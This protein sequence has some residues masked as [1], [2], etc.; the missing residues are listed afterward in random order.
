MSKIG[1]LFGSFN[2][3]HY[4]HLR[5]A[6]LSV[7]SGVVDKVWLVPSKQNPFKESYEISDEDRLAMVRL[8]TSYPF[9]DYCPIEF[10][11][12]VTS[13][14]TYDIY[15]CIKSHCSP[16]DSLVIICGSDMYDEIPKWYRGEELLEEDFYI[17]DRDPRDISSS[18]IRE[19]IKAG[20]DFKEFVPEEVYNYIKEN[21]L[22]V[23]TTEAQGI[24]AK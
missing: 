12:E 20:Q 23:N 17:F 6:N 8:T 9:V 13:T 24:K 15:N 18:M 4:G 22:Y 21:N 11:N 3:V 2:P 19:K 10:T 16:K 14:R 7:K 1:L 5:I